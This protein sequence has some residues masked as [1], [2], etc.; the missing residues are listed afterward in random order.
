MKGIGIDVVVS[1]KKAMLYGTILFVV[2]IAFLYLVAVVL[3]NEPL[4][5]IIGLVIG[6]IT[7][8]RN[9][10]GAYKDMKHL[11]ETEGSSSKVEIETYNDFKE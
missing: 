2:V 3:L 9:M 8:I 5:F 10:I 1:G 11:E 4:F 7:Y 6:I